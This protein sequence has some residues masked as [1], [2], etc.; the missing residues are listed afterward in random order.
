M[1]TVYKLY[2]AHGNFGVSY[3]IVCGILSAGI[4]AILT[5]WMVLAPVSPV[6]A[7]ESFDGR[8]F[9]WSDSFGWISLNC[10][11]DWNGDGEPP[12]DRCGE[13]QYGVDF[14]WRGLD[15]TIGGTAWSP[16]LGIICFDSITPG[17]EGLRDPVG[18]NPLRVAY[19]F[20]EGETVFLTE[21]DQT[22]E[23][24]PVRGWGR[25]MGHQNSGSSGQGGWIQFDGRLRA[26]S[27]EDRANGGGGV[28]LRP[29]GFVEAGG[30]RQR[31][32]ELVLAGS[33]WQQNNDGTG[34]GWIYLGEAP[35]GRPGEETEVSGG[36]STDPIPEGVAPPAVEREDECT[37]GDALFC[38]L[39]RQ[40]DDGDASYTGV[41]DRNGAT[42]VDCQDYDCAG[43]SF[44]S[45]TIYNAEASDPYLHC[46]AIPLVNG[47]P[48]NQ[49][50]LLNSD[51]CFDGFDN[52]LDRSIDCSDPDCSEAE[53]SDGQR[54]CRAEFIARERDFCL[55]GIDN[56]G[57]EVSDCADD[58]C[59]SRA[60]L[61]V[62]DNFLVGHAQCAG[63]ALVGACREICP[64]GT[65]D[66][67]GDRVCSSIDNCPDVENSTQVDS[68][69]NGRG[70][71]CDAFLETKAGSIYAP[72]L[73]VSRPPPRRATATYCILTTGAQRFVPFNAQSERCDLPPDAAVS[74]LRLRQYTDTIALIPSLTQDILRSRIDVAGLRRGRYGRV[75][76]AN[77]ASEVVRALQDR[78]ALAPKVITYSGD[79]QLEGEI[80]IPSSRGGVTVLVD[81]NILFG[82]AARFARIV[83]ESGSITDTRKIPSVAWIALDPNLRDDVI[84]GNIR[85]AS[86]VGELVGALF[87]ADTIA[88]G[89][90]TAQ[91]QVHGLMVARRFSFERQYI[92]DLTSPLTVPQGAEVVIYDGRVALNPPPGLV[93]FVKTLPTSNVAPR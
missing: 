16:N 30:R 24:A 13:G 87:A 22:I 38:C 61:C 66:R 93:D 26:R 84:E 29:T 79:L 12:E 51:D 49:E 56:D 71:A 4:L 17:C 81:G 43:V 85:V 82:T 18:G 35:P 63:G 7:Q 59:R 73:R 47:R 70:D 11:N 74:E 68:N 52:D 21:G 90:G 54:T 48:T 31:T 8:G 60:G 15:G 92:P 40:D 57:D 34:V 76:T 2:A 91:L 86:S 55:D 46:G 89:S 83:Y 75:F 25:V 5:F 14:V 72:R 36:Q 42:G 37:D 39:N 33:A 32:F 10:R 69:G 45:A 19:S 23:V 67:D 53:H 88:T 20:R 27:L 50:N 41:P 64:R 65:H 44:Y 6:A 62:G 3:A 78:N 28:R 58:E 80:A 77:T 1:K 9:W